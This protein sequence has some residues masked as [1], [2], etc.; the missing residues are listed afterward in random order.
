MAQTTYQVVLAVDGHHSVSVTSDDPAA[1]TEALVWARQ[2]HR[3]LVRIGRP[4]GQPA[5]PEN[6]PD[7]DTQPGQAPDLQPD[8][9]TVTDPPIC[10]VHQIPMVRMHGR[11]G[12]FWSC[13]QRNPDRSFCSYRPPRS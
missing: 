13:H 7:Q 4:P 6:G 5:P 8:D 1:V 2:V 3:Q 12:A 9:D 10:E 11:R